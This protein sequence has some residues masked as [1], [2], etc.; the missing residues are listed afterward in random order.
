ME[1]PVI[2]TSLPNTAQILTL[3]SQMVHLFGV[4]KDC[5]HACLRTV[6]STGSLQAS[7]HLKR[8]TELSTTL[9]QV[10]FTIW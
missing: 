2:G 8:H 9:Q 1:N 6:K 5:E 4:A 7:P 10:S 3:L